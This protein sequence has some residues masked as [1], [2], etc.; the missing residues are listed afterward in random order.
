M[1]AAG[2]AG[3]GGD[4]ANVAQSGLQGAPTSC[5]AAW[6]ESD[7]H[8]CFWCS[9]ALGE[10]RWWC[11]ARRSQSSLVQLPWPDHGLRTRAFGTDRSLRRSGG[12]ASESGVWDSILRTSELETGVEALV[13]RVTTA[14][15][16]HQCGENDYRFLG[17]GI[18][19]S[20]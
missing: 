7:R 10:Q 8:K 2:W 14:R 16:G 9:A 5:A 15:A 3:S 19:F 17:H 13:L 20:S 4:S 1:S 11:C 18:Y 12:R 6:R